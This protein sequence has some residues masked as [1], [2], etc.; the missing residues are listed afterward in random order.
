VEGRVHEA[1]RLLLEDFVQDNAAMIKDTEE[2][3]AY[4]NKRKVKT[5]RT[6]ELLLG[7]AWEKFRSELL[8][9]C[10]AI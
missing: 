1:D 10:S 6:K 4:L 2:Q 5:E 7:P 9:S 8:L 3:I